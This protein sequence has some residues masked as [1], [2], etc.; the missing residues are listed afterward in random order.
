M[1][2]GHHELH[3]CRHETTT[4]RPQTLQTRGRLTRWAVS[5]ALAVSAF[6]SSIGAPGGA[7]QVVQ[8]G[9]P[10][11]DPGTWITDRFNYR[12]T[13]RVDNASANI[14]APSIKWAYP[15]GGGP[16]AWM[17]DITGPGGLPDGVPELITY[18]AG[19]VRAYNVQAASPALLWQTEQL[20]ANMDLVFVGD[21]DGNGDV[22]I[23][24]RAWQPMG[25]YAI[26]GRDG[27]VLSR[28]D[29]LKRF[30]VGA[31]WFL[32]V[33]VADADGDGRMELF[34]FDEEDPGGGQ[35]IYTYKN[36][37]ANP[38]LVVRFTTLAGGV[39][40]RGTYANLADLDGDQ[41]PEVIY[42]RNDALHIVSTVGPNAWTIV[43][44]I[45]IPLAGFDSFASVWITD[46]ITTTPGLEI[47]TGRRPG[48]LDV[49]NVN[50]STL[51]ITVAYQQSLGFAAP[52][53]DRIPVAVGDLDGN[54]GLEVL[55]SPFQTVNP[56]QVRAAADGSLLATAPL[57]QKSLTQFLTHA[58]AQLDTDPQPEI[59]LQDGNNVYVYGYQ[60]G[61]NLSHTITEASISNWLSPTSRWFSEDARRFTLDV[62][63]DNVDELLIF[64]PNSRR[65][66]A[67]DVSGAT[68]VLRGVY[69]YPA[70][71]NLSLQYVGNTPFG[72]GLVLSGSD[73]NIYVL[74]ATFNLRRQVYAGVGRVTPFVVDTN[75]DGQRELLFVNFAGEWVNLNPLTATFASPPLVNYVTNWRPQ[76]LAQMGFA[77]LM[78]LVPVISTP[79]AWAFPLVD[80]SQAPTYTLQLRTKHPLNGTESVVVSRVFTEGYGFPIGLGLGQFAGG[81]GSP[82]D[83]F[84]SLGNAWSGGAGQVHALNGQTLQT[85]WTSYRLPEFITVAV[86]DVD[87]DGLDDLL[88]TMVGD[89]VGVARRGATGAAMM[90]YS[91]Y[92]GSAMVD[93]FDADPDQEAFYYGGA[94]GEFRMFDPGATPTTKWATFIAPA[95]LRSAA[96][97]AA[98]TPTNGR[99][100]AYSFADGTLHAYEGISGTLIYSRALGIGFDTATCAPNINA[101]NSYP[102]WQRDIYETTCPGAGRFADLGVPLVAN[103]DGEPNDEILVGSDNGY[104]Y[105]LNAEN[106]TL[107]WAHN[108]YYPIGAVIAANVDSDPALEI[109]VSVADGYLYALDQGELARPQTA[110][111]GPGALEMQDIDTQVDTQCFQANWRVTADPVYGLPQGF[112]VAIRDETGTL[113]SNGY[114]DVTYAAG[115]V[116]TVKACYNDPNPNRRLVTNL[117]RGKRYFAE[118]INYKGARTSA[119]M[120]SDGALVA[121]VADFSASAKSAQPATALPGDVVTWT[122]VIRNTG[123]FAGDAQLRDPIPLNMTFVPGSVSANLGTAGYN[124]GLNRVEWQGT[125]APGQVATVTFQAQVNASFSA[126]LI[127]N[128]AE[129]VDLTNGTI[130]PLAATVAV[131]SPNLNSAEKQVSAA[132]AFQT[133]VLTYTLRVTNTG[134]TTATG[135][136]VSDTL[137]AGLSFVVGSLSASGGS[138]SASYN[139]TLKRVRWIGSL[140]PGQA[141][142]VVFRAQVNAVNGVI[143]NCADFSD[144]TGATAR[145]C[146]QT[147]VGS[148]GSLVQ[149]V[150][151]ADR[152]AYNPG[153][154]ITYTVVVSNVGT[155]AASVVVNDPM[156]AG[157]TVNTVS[158]FPTG[159]TLNFSPSSVS[160]TGVLNPNSYVVLTIRA[161][162]SASAGDGV[163]TNRAFITN[164]TA[165][166]SQQVVREVVVGNAPF[167]NG[168][169]QSDPLGARPG[170]TV[171]YTLRLFNTGTAIATNAVLTDPLPFGVA[172]GGYAVANVGVVSYN[173]TLQR[174]EWSGPVF[175]TQP[176]VIT[177]TVTV[178]DAAP[179]GG[180]VV[181]QAYSYDNVSDYDQLVAVTAVNVPEGK[182]LIRG[183]VYS[184]TL[185]A[186][187]AGALVS[188]SGL[189]GTVSAYSNASGFFLM[190][191]DAGAQ[192]QDYVVFLAVPSG[193]VAL[194][195]NPVGLGG[196]VDGDVRDVVFRVAAPASGGFG[197]V[198]GV[199]F[200]DVN[201]DGQRNIFTEPG[202]PG[203][204]V[205]ASS[206]QSAMT[207]ADGSYYLLVPAGSRAI[208][209]T[210]LVGWLS[211]TPD[212]VA[213]NVMSGGDHEVNFGDRLCA[214][215]APDCEPPSA[216]FARLEGYVYA[217]ADGVL[218][219]PDGLRST[220]DASLSGVVVTVDDGN[221]FYNATTNVNGYF[222]VDVPASGS[223]LVEVSV[224][225]PSGYQLLTPSPLGMELQVGPCWWK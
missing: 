50:P 133:A 72:R 213:V 191:V 172:Y 43:S 101:P 169:K 53:S 203:V 138:G 106:G 182:A 114:L 211:T 110:W 126:G 141:L 164:T 204:T 207:G 124:S 218:N 131:N 40:C 209:Q 214:P 99:D 27:A 3:E 159:G 216:G 41:V 89:P 129:V 158:Q 49:F 44:A 21:V 98:V 96:A 104:L 22:E 220:S 46:V 38:E 82:W 51:S 167:I 198:R 116:A 90:P 132:Q 134:T 95:V 4:R 142:E 24:V 217:D 149:A 108:F 57:P 92:R 140:G 187:L 156:P 102:G 73:G 70:G 112:R 12:R 119:P 115:A 225:V 71:V 35:T 157:V 47:V 105:V 100:I 162:I 6:V 188:A 165:S 137:P 18:G 14:T 178:L 222:Q 33:Q 152:L 39:C 189:S 197:W 153:D 148:G 13:N 23:I 42:D 10:V 121:N 179:T 2:R 54:P 173:A 28:V 212:V 29:P 185:D 118:V 83:M 194:T 103:V 109:L 66:A 15:V 88:A 174:L 16:S 68:P 62:N 94:A 151:T 93:N 56:F 36:G 32:R 160:W 201:G 78:P 166:T 224:T 125:L 128:Q 154:L 79:P 122:V 55:L 58:S 210:N 193:L 161:Q 20:P 168:D 219:A 74:D 48:R 86:A 1:K 163:L 183:Y 177:W 5:L 202:I 107:R 180:V 221:N 199:V 176:T 65:I 63:N 84:V 17:H 87:Q 67:Y 205:Q 91:G 150:K 192:P 215:G 76:L 200:H 113:V 9:G 170:D 130:V 64:H 190:L 37:A 127:Q 61:L 120:F 59:V 7:P 45:T 195:P 52:E 60:G 11:P 80:V 145:R 8:A 184:G 31:G 111:D 97:A 26:R 208:T 69:T 181:N 85:V 135:T 136:L 186:P 171:T 123:E 155:Q 117:L 25:H 19:R 206:G 144:Q 30:P 75:S 81:P 175:I 223:V 34:F 139:S 146:A 143:N 196:V 77:A 147:V